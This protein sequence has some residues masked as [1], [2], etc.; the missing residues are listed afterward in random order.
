MLRLQKLSGKRI[1]ENEGN[2]GKIEIFSEE[3]KMEEKKQMKLKAN[4]KEHK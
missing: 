1:Y 2:E 3:M 4:S